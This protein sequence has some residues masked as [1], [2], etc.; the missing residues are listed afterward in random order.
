MRASFDFDIEAPHAPTDQRVFVRRL[1]RGL[2]V[3][4]DRR[5]FRRDL[6]IA[7]TAPG[8]LVREEAVLRFDL[9]RRYV[10][11]L[12]RGRL[13]PL[14]RTGAGLLIQRAPETHR[15]ARFGVQMIV[16]IVFAD[17][18]VGL[19]ID[20]LNLG[21][22]ALQ[23]LADHHRVRGQDALAQI[24]LI[25]A[26]QHAV[27]GGDDNPG[28]DLDAAVGGRQ[29]GARIDDVSR[30]TGFGGGRMGKIQRHRHAAA[31]GRG[32]DEKL[33]AIDFR[34][35]GCSSPPQPLAIKAAALRMPLRI[36]A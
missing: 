23:F 32:G 29:P 16:E 31:N 6:T 15:A 22:V 33:S 2:A 30:D 17:M 36:S 8:S 9:R 1:D 27:I 19:G 10:P 35:H 24:R 28:I 4:F 12:R 3:Q 7:Q 34:R 14:A 26:D 13:Q 20:A 21:P 11:F 5:G 25:D 18:A